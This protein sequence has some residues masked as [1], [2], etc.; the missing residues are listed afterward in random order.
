MV[1]SVV[2]CGIVGVLEVLV[3]MIFSGIDVKNVGSIYFFWKVVCKVVWFVF[4]CE[5]ESVVGVVLFD[6]DEVVSK[7]MNCLIIIYY[8]VVVEG[9][10]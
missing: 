10:E 7:I 5:I 8:I 1:V 9:V 3:I 6:R 4:V 2:R